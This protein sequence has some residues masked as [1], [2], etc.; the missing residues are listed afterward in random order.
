MDPV[1]MDALG[2]HD[3]S[4]VAAVSLGQ[5]LQEADEAKRL[6]EAKRIA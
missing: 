5:T 4:D 6:A 1:F 2:I 3:A